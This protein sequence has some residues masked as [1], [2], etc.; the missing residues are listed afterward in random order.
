[1]TPATPSSLP[2]SGGGATSEGAAWPW[3]A[4]AAAGGLVLMLSASL[5]WLAKE[6]SEQ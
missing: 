2:P 3:L 5:V 1:V 4:L 6:R